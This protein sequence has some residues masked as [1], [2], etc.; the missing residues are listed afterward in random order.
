MASRAMKTIVAVGD[1]QAVVEFT[2]TGDDVEARVDGT[3]YRATVTRNGELW[4]IALPD[5]TLALT[6]VR[7]HERAW[8]AVDG[9]V[10]RCELC[11]EAPGGGTSLGVRSPRVVAP[12]P[13]KVLEVLVRE[14]QQVAAGDPLVIL[15]AMKMETVASAEA[16]ARILRV[17]VTA[18]TMVEPGQVLVDLEF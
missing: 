10:Y 3:P 7:D 1:R 11:S 9:E 8:I 4:R 13:G 15:E 14:G 5:R 17:H 2:A 18:G 12:M 6:V 16:A